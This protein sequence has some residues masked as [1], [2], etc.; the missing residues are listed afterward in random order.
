[1]AAYVELYIDQGTTFSNIININD[2]TTNTPVNIQGYIVSS[3]IRRSYYSAN[4]TANI[5]CTI[6]NALDGEITMSMTAANT[7]NIKAGRYLF[8]VETIDTIG[9]VSRILEGI[10]TVTPQI[11]R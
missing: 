4:A 5:T 2:D 6:T 10:I 7:S 1:M 9:N 3:Q 8:D 11:T